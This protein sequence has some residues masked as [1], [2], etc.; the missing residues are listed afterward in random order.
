MMWPMAG[1]QSPREHKRQGEETE[2][3]KRE[4]KA[5]RPARSPITLTAGRHPP[6]P[7][8]SR[9]TLKVGRG[10]LRPQQ[11]R[12]ENN[13]QVACCHSVDLRLCRNV[14][15]KRKEGLQHRQV[16]LRQLP[17]DGACCLGLFFRVW[18]FYKGAGEGEATAQGAPSIERAVEAH[19]ALASGHTGAY[20]RGE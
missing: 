20:L 8:A 14:A 18:Q 16:L 2:R 4:S 10:V 15:Q 13:G 12:S 17:H 5:G 19:H 9:L 1:E 3:G 6:L 11:V 7:P